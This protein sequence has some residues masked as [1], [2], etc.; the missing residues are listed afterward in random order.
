MRLVITIEGNKYGYSG[1]R[2]TS[3]YVEVS[4]RQGKK[5]KTERVSS[6][7][8]LLAIRRRGVEWLKDDC[9]VQER[10][11]QRPVVRSSAVTTPRPTN[12]F[13]ELVS[14]P[15]VIPH[16]DP[17][18]SKKLAPS[19]NTKA[20]QLANSIDRSKMSNR[21]VRKIER[22]IR[23]LSIQSDNEIFSQTA[24]PIRH[25]LNRLKSQ[26]GQS[27]LGNPIEILYHGTRSTNVPSILKQGFRLDKVSYGRMLGDGVYLGRMTKAVNYC[28]FIV[29]KVAVA[30]GRCLKVEGR[31]TTLE[32][33]PEYDSI[34]VASGVNNAV[35]K[36]FLFNEEWCVRD[37]SR[38]EI[39]EIVHVP[40]RWAV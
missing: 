35:W 3:N 18:V 10:T 25:D 19:S 4:Y 36:G 37:P 22:R 28:D 27:T 23:R 34:H 12:K 39:I 6:I 38:C 17:E 40:N 29:L 30:L 9:K 14:S 16:L 31:L 8:D 15:E 21:T 13:I 1:Y 5:E 26:F 20:N 32:Q 24:I 7:Q 11:V 33:N 2:N